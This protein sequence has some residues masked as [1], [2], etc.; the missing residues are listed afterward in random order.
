MPNDALP[1]SAARRFANRSLTHYLTSAYPFCSA[2]TSSPLSCFLSV[3]RVPS[4]RF[5]VSSS[6]SLSCSLSLFLSLPPFLHACS[7][8]PD[9]DAAEDCVSHCPP[10][11]RFLFS[12][13]SHHLSN[14]I[15]SQW[16]FCPGPQIPHYNHVWINT[17]LWGFYRDVSHIGT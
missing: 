11:Q 13:S 3:S 7:A 1:V 12:P 4:P 8:C 10:A 2:S 14:V 6:P 5:P 15:I 17:I 16:S 9:P